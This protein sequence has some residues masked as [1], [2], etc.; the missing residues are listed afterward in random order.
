[1]SD[2][3]AAPETCKKCGGGLRPAGGCKLCVMFTTGQ[4]PSCVSDTTRFPGHLQGGA[5]FTNPAVRASYLAK[6]RAAGVNPAGKVY[7]SSLAA[8]PGDPRAWAD[9]KGDQVKLLEDRG[10]SADGDVK[11][12]GREV[13]PA[14]PVRLAEDLVQGRMEREL[15]QRY[16]DAINGKTVKIKRR[17]LEDLR[18]GIIEKHGAPKPG[19]A[20]QVK[21]GR[22]KPGKPAG[23][24]PA[25]RRAPWFSSAMTPRPN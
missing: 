4:T 21:V 25:T 19:A 16:P 24:R 2:T 22:S 12:K 9:S 8:C 7:S 23:K 17:D 6:A 10:W 11:V 20:P 5:Q 13:E 15:E 14:A 3:V 1:M 18:E